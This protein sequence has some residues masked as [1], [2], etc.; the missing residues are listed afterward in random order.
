M[1]LDDFTQ[2]YLECALWSSMDNST[3]QGG[4]PLD[5]NYGVEDFSPEAVKQAIE[6]CRLFQGDNAG[7]LYRACEVSG[8]RYGA[9]HA[10][11]D[12]WLTRNRHGA[13]FWDRGLCK[14]GEELT[15]A[16][17][18]WGPQDVYVGDSGKLYFG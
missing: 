15:A 8:G 7:D 5:G 13:G 16:A 2:A 4:Y 12:F 1:R 9:E 18:I 10:G 11:H 6:D 14:L 3:E 17:H